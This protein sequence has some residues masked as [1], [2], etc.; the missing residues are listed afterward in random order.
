M[1]KNLFLEAIHLHI[2][3]TGVAMY[4]GFYYIALVF[5]LFFCKD[6]LMRMRIA[7]PALIMLSFILGCAP[8]IN[9]YLI[10]IYDK[11]TGGRLF[12]VLLITPVI[13]YGMVCVVRALDGYWKKALLI[14]TLVPVIFLSGVFKFSNALYEPVENEYRL[15]QNGIDI[16]NAVLEVVDEPKLLV[17]Y[18]TAHIFRQYSTDIKLLYGEDASYGRIQSVFGT[19]YHT[20]CQEMDSTTPDVKFVASLA[21][22]E[23][24]DFIIFD[25]SYHVLGEAPA[26]YG[27]DYYM[28]IDHFDLYK[29]R[30]SL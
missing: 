24:C 3:Y 19:D 13:A 27:Y 5:I 20:A 7:Y 15:P 30:K 1:L 4:M 23:N 22:R 28:M 14:M 8:Y 9:S 2:A 10:G 26:L 25:M 6:K 16:C 18:E 21:Y 29:R 11:D 17:P 12:W